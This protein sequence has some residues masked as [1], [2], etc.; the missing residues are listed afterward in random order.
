MLSIKEYIF[1][2]SVESAYEQLERAGKRGTLIAGGAF[3]NLGRKTIGTALDLSRA[4]LDG[5]RQ[6]EEAVEIGAMVSLGALDRAPELDPAITGFLRRSCRDVV[7]I[8]LRNMATFGG[9]VHSRYG[10]SDLLTAL[11]TL[12]TSAVFHRAG[13]IP[14]SVYLEEGVPGPD[15]LTGIRLERTLDRWGY[16]SLRRSTGDFPILTAA[17]SRC[18]GR[19]RAAVGAR[20]MRAKRAETLMAALDARAVELKDTDRLGE[21]LMAD[22]QFGSNSRASRD[23]RQ[24]VCGVLIGDALKEAG[25]DA[26]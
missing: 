16:Q 10:F 24:Q 12:D 13:E 21:L 5:L 17:V 3:L 2:D 25:Y 1:P 19:W 4:G 26:G 9:T 11:V 8:Q 14:L 6:D 15:I 23:Y 7:G 22:L 20:P 18:G